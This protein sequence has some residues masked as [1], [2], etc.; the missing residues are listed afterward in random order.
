MEEFRALGEIQARQRA[1]SE[2]KRKREEAEKTNLEA[3]ILKGNIANCRCC[4][5]EYALDHMVHCGRETL[6]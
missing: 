2:I 6:H 5:I 4:F 1:E 3:A